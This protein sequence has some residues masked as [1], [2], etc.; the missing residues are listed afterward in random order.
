MVKFIDTFAGIGGFRLGAER[1]FAA[2]GVPA[3]CVMSVELDDKACRT[4][5]ANFGANPSGDM[6]KLSP[7]D[8]PDH[9]LLLGGFPCQAFSRNGKYYN[10][11]NR[12]LGDDD[13]ANLCFRL[14]DVLKAK[15]PKFFV[16]ENVKELLT[17]KNQD[18]SSFL[19]GI[20]GHL[21]DCGYDVAYNLMNSSDFGLPQQRKRVYFVGSRKDLGLG[22]VYSPPAATPLS[23]AVRDIMEPA[24]PDRYLL[25]SLW[26]NR[27]NVKIGGTR[28][29]ALN[30]AYNSGE[31]PRPTSRVDQIVPVAIIYGDTPSG[32]PRQ[33]DKMY[34]SWGIS[35]T[36]A[37]FSTP[38]FDADTGWRILTPRE[39]AR[40]QG[41]PDDFILPT[42]VSSAYKQVGNAVSI[43]VVS[44]VIG[45]VA[46]MWP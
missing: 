12:T 7:H 5:E 4:Y 27:K 13:R 1:A 21:N 25:T 34:S 10:H 26:R 44:A 6:T 28:L 46:K 37:T 16:F 3:Q 38:A 36:I 11:N 45:A 14:F 22:G 39:C 20:L 2:A 23:V 31:W 17:I 19:E 24:V 43:N 30:Q 40:A 33:Q 35:P 18:G 41:F 29:E 9:D 32:A 42:S 8:F 15:Q